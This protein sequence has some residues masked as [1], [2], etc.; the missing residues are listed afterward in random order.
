MSLNLTEELRF[1]YVHFKDSIDKIHTQL[2]QWF[3]F[4]LANGGDIK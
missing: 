3:V 1:S 2:A 4:T